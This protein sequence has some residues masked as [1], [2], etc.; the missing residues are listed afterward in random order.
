MIAGMVVFACVFGSKCCKK[1]EKKK[2]KSSTIGR[3]GG[4]NTKPV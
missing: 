3:K 1:E 2:I 4:S